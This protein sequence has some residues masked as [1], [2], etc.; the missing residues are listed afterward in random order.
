MAEGTI[1]EP[2]YVGQLLAAL[3]QRL[4]GAQVNHER[5]RR[6]Q[7]R[8]IVVWERFKNQGHPERQKMVW[9]IAGE[10]LNKA[11]IMNVAMIITV[12][13]AELVTQ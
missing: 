10:V 12:A 3:T 13:P 11:D 6:D 2:T 1:A 4:T 9:D 7:Y 5:V 8:F